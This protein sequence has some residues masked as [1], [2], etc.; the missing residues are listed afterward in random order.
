MGRGEEHPAEDLFTGSQAGTG[1][2]RNVY[3]GTWHWTGQAAAAT[4]GGGRRGHGDHAAAE[5][6]AGSPR[7]H[8]PRQ[9]A[10]R[11]SKHLAHKLPDSGTSCSGTFLLVIEQF[12]QGPAEVLDCL[13][14]GPGLLAA[15]GRGQGL[16]DSA[17]SALFRLPGDRNMPF[18]V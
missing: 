18:L 17:L 4:G 8:E 2:P 16:R 7:P 11:G 3:W 14:L 9:G 1:T 6:H 5:G 10:V 13:P 12:C 15:G